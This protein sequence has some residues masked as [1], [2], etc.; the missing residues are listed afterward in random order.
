[1]TSVVDA[2]PSA[3]EKGGVA[4]LAQVKVRTLSALV[5]RSDDRTHLAAITHDIGVD[6]PSP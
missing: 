5:P 3:V 6:L 1:M 2:T 4:G